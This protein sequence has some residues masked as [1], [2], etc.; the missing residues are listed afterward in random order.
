M[1]KRRILVIDDE[2]EVCE[3]VKSML[4]AKGY[5]TLTAL[6]GKEGLEKAGAE[7]PDLVLLDIILPDIEGFDVLSKLKSDSKT[8]HIP[9]VIVSG[10]GDYDSIVRATSSRSADYLIKP[11]TS[12]ELSKIISRSLGSFSLTPQQTDT[13]LIAQACEKLQSSRRILEKLIRGEG[14][15]RV[16]AEDAL[17]DL[18]GVIESL[19]EASK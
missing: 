6:T 4:E 1:A 18:N 14:V 7:Q 5:E 9:V 11:F 10:K 15:M 8:Q 16:F 13:E 2:K 17:K 19:R 12:Q 3:L